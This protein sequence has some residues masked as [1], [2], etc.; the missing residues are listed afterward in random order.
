MAIGI[1]THWT[2][3]LISF[4]SLIFVYLA[5]VGLSCDTWDL[6]FLVAA[7]RLLACGR[8]SASLGGVG[9][10]GGGLALLSWL[11]VVLI[12][13][14]GRI[15]LCV[16]LPIWPVGSLKERHVC[17]PSYPQHDLNHMRNQKPYKKK[18]EIF[19]KG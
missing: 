12:V 17:L 6:F 11:Y 16:C 5:V 19:K 13:L 10:L 9:L 14:P 1:L 4:F 3:L 2:T 8:V 15:C 7:Y 18:I